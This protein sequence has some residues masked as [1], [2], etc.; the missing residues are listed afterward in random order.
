M[1]RVLVGVIFFCSL[2]WIDSV[3]S[4]DVTGM[5]LDHYLYYTY[6]YNGG[7]DNAYTA[8]TRVNNSAG[9]ETKGESAGNLYSELSGELGFLP[10]WSFI[11]G[12]AGI[13]RWNSGGSGGQSEYLIRLSRANLIYQFHFKRVSWLDH[14]KLNVG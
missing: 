13:G 4:F 12:V 3:K 6:D 8:N 5:K 1:K 10:H 9:G 7:L 14:L 11:G 2:F